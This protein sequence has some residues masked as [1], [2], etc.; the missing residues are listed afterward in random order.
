[1]SRA[2]RRHGDELAAAPA[3]GPAAAQGA[4]TTAS[5]RGCRSQPD[6]RGHTTTRAPS[7]ARRGAERVQGGAAKCVPRPARCAPRRRGLRP[8]GHLPAPRGSACAQWRRRQAGVTEVEVDAREVRPRRQTPQHGWA[9]RY[10]RTPPARP[11]GRSLLSRAAASSAVAGGTAP[12][13][14]RRC[15]SPATR[16]AR[17]T[18]RMR[19]QRLLVPV[20]EGG[21]GW[22]AAQGF[23]PDRATRA[24]PRDPP[25]VPR[26][27]H[28][29]PETTRRAPRAPRL[30]PCGRWP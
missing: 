9:G 1:M 26:A 28:H 27:R 13:G 4:M 23:S 8:T 29:A 19:V 12:L 7:A 21:G 18:S 16:P 15:V 22:A 14:A 2:A 6:G 5:R 17:R 24:G 11:A 30:V 20:T 25:P 10:A 3:A